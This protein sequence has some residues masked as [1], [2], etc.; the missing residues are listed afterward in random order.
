MIYIYLNNVA[1][2]EMNNIKIL[3]TINCIHYLGIDVFISIH[4][5]IYKFY[6]VMYLLS[7]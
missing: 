6:I 2:K 3:D 7:Y 4:R 5:L 1:V